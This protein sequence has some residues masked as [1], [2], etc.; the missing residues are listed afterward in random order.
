RRMFAAPWFPGWGDRRDPEDGQPLLGAQAMRSEFNNV[1]DDPNPEGA[2]SP[3]AR[4]EQ[5]ELPVLGT[6]CPVP[7]LWPQGSSTLSALPGAPKPAV[8][9][10]SGHSRTVAVEGLRCVPRR[11]TIPR[12]FL[13]H[14]ERAAEQV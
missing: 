5:N 2:G 4:H 12:S 7:S 9:M 3:N 13:S 10:P 1:P 14:G 11:T 6:G 8:D